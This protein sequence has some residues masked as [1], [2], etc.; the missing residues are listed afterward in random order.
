MGGWEGGGE[1][2]R[3]GWVGEGEREKAGLPQRRRGLRRRR[4]EALW[5]GG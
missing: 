5:V 3:G 4:S 1:V 2:R